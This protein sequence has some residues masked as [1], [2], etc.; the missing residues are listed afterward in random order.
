MHWWADVEGK[1][2]VKCHP[3]NLY[4]REV[5]AS[6]KEVEMAVVLKLFRDQQLAEPFLFGGGSTS[7]Q[8]LFEN[9]IWIFTGWRHEEIADFLC[10]FRL[11]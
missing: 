8:C 6:F 5:V 4:R 9:V 2:D 11:Q 7:N 1:A 10:D 3:L